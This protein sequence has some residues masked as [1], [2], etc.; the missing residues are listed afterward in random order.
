MSGGEIYSGTQS[1]SGFLA[2]CSYA[3]LFLGGRHDMG[4]LV[5]VTI[6]A[7]TV[8]CWTVRKL[9][10]KPVRWRWTGLEWVAALSIGLLILQLTPLS[11]PILTTFAPSLLEL[12]PTWDL[13][14]NSAV[15]FG[16]WNRLS[17]TPELTRGALVLLISYWLLFFVVADHIRNLAD[18][19]RILKWIAL[20]AVSMAVIGI[21]QRFFGNGKFLWVYEH[22][23]RNTLTAVKGAFTNENHFAHFLALGIAP[24]ILWIRSSLIAEEQS[25]RSSRWNKKA[26]ASK[27]QLRSVSL[28][29]GLCLVVFAGLLS[30]S[31]GGVAV[32]F[33]TS[34][35]AVVGLASIGM[36]GRRAVLGVGLAGGVV[37][38]AVFIFGYQP[39]LNEWHTIDRAQTIQELSTG[40]FELWNSMLSATADFPFFG[41]GAGSHA[42]V[43]PAFFDTPAYSHFSHGENGYIQIALETGAVGVLVL[44]SLIGMLGYSLVQWFRGDPDKAAMACMIVTVAG[45]VASA[46]HSLCDFV[47]YIPACFTLT[48]VLLALACRIMQLNSSNRVET[49]KFEPGYPVAFAMGVAL[50]FFCGILVHQRVGPGLASYSWDRYYAL[51][52]HTG[53]EEQQ[54]FA[55]TNAVDR[56]YVAPE[57]RLREMK[58]YLSETLEW[59]P[60]NSRAMLR[61]ASLDL[62]Q[63]QQQQAR[64]FAS[65]PLDQI[66]DVAQNS[67][68]ASEAARDTWLDNVLGDRIGLL[69]RASILSELSLRL[70]P[71]EGRG[72]LLLAESG[73]LF[74]WKDER[75]TALFKQAKQVRPFDELVL[76]KC[77][78]EKIRS[79]DVDEAI[80]DWKAAFTKSPA[81]RSLAIDALTPVYSAEQLADLLKDDWES[82][83]QLYVRYKKLGLEED[84]TYIARP[85]AKTIESHAKEES[86]Y[87]AAQLLSQAGN[88]YAHLE[89]Y[90]DS[91]R[92]LRKSTQLSP[93]NFGYRFA[94]AGRLMKAEKFD[95]AVAEYKWCRRRQP[96]NDSV[97][98]QLEKAYKMSVTHKQVTAQTPDRIGKV[99]THQA[100]Q[101]IQ[102]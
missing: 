66:V 75:R 80:A 36:L 101:T 45:L 93:N 76:H 40:R 31:R 90:E 63:F 87:V 5:L 11:R 27:S 96:K 23:S 78:I 86:S 42:E 24:L 7:L 37:T 65:L 20:A 94:L 53:V 28:I 97:V 8:A 59:D 54:E 15:N 98:L 29:V 79:G 22:P 69:K 58:R 43:Y 47:W 64:L 38:A 39:L 46:A 1:T 9:L 99:D 10:Q 44:C 49:K 26:T 32:V 16:S 88:V 21:S 18:V 61:L 19:Q 2:H 57:F 56:D 68:F 33:V 55:A 3:P 102:R 82:L 62:R 17:L 25:E 35:V 13:Q 51:S 34:F 4:R 52:R 67:D 48:V 6:I 81:I 73:Q 72:Y 70:S 71:L 100:D 60:A 91:I 50:L 84:A 41:T 12:L 89:Q 85:L 74:G 30:F 92:C 14:S 95:D 83:Y 77:A